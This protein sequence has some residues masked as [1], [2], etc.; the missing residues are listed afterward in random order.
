MK[1][2]PL[3]KGD[4]THLFSAIAR[5]EAEIMSYACSEQE[6]RIYGLD[7]ESQSKAGV[8]CEILSIPKA[9]VGN[10]ET[11]KSLGNKT[12]PELSSIQISDEDL[13]DEH[14]QQSASM[15]LQVMLA[16][17]GLA[18]I[19]FGITCLVDELSDTTLNVKCATK[20]KTRLDLKVFQIHD[21]VVKGKDLHNETSGASE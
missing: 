6:Y 3:S 2:G 8:T 12:L 18:Y 11:R 16:L 14:L 1:P 7:G 20:K 19:C 17:L 10:P 15:K 21:L 4:M 5:K 13:V 9:N